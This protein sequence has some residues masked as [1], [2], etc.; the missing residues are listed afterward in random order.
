MFFS[1][2]GVN[3][4][5]LIRCLIEVDEH[6]TDF[7]IGNTSNQT[8]ISESGGLL[9]LSTNLGVVNIDLTTNKVRAAVQEQHQQQE[10]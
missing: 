7:A 10:Q 9:G 5:E 2:N 8:S 1:L 6:Q 4:T 3:R